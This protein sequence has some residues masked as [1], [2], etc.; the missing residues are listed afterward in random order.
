MGKPK[1]SDT[2]RNSLAKF[3]KT[4]KKTGRELTRAYIP[5]ALDRGERQ[6]DISRYYHVGRSTIW[7]AKG[8][9]LAGASTGPLT[10][11]AGRGA[12]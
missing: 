3:I 11:G 7:R 4:G 6:G 1:L 5:L 10:T 8:G 9:Y 12:L 2:D